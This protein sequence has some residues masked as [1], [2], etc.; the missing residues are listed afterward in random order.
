VAGT[1]G[2]VAGGDWYDAFALP[3]GRFGVVIGDIVG[4]G[5]RAAATM[6]R[7]RNALRAYAIDG[8]APT[9]VLLR[10]HRLTEAFDDVPFATVLYLMLDASTGEG[11]LATAGHLPPLL[12]GPG[13]DAGY[14]SLCPGPPLGAPA[15]GGWPEARLL[16]EPGALLVL[17]TDGLVEEPGRPLA[18]GLAQLARAATRLDGD[19]EAVTD[20]ILA[21]LTEGR[22]RPDDIAVLSLRSKR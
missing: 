17:Y 6:G 2:S 5:I 12:V 10:L 22:T 13:G 7:L 9:D 18:D 1:Q 21:D 16:L 11:R 20:G 14:A 15:A 3:D 19:I 4:R 8:D